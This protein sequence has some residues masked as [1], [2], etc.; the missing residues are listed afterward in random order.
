MK[1]GELEGSEGVLG[2]EHNIPSRLSVMEF[3]FY[4]LQFSTFPKKFQRDEKMK[5]HVLGRDM[6]APRKPSS[7]ACLGHENIELCSSG[8]LYETLLHSRFFTKL[9][10]RETCEKLCYATPSS[11]VSS[12][13]YRS[14]EPCHAPLNSWTSDL[15]NLDH[16]GIETRS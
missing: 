3:R 7:D 8:S 13:G 6:K 9:V 10:Y 12:G 4:S 1:V 14:Q 2:H 5:A 16:L 15:Q 11:W